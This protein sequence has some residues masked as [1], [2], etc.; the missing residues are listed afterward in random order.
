MLWLE[1]GVQREERVGGETDGAQGTD[2]R[3]GGEP[4]EILEQA[5]VFP[6]LPLVFLSPVLE[7]LG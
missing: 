6:G 4:G 7:G 1:C 5:R 3:G 2:L